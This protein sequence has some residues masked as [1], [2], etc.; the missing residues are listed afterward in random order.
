ML[1]NILG[2]DFESVS[3]ISSMLL[4]VN[5]YQYY[6]V[7]NEDQGKVPMFREDFTNRPNISV[8]PTKHFF[9]LRT[10]VQSIQLNGDIPE[11]RLVEAPELFLVT[12]HRDSRFLIAR[13]RPNNYRS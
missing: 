1:G 2:S 5:A 8:A 12:S 13:T 9:Q 10:F 7:C 4:F 6:P 11:F 3:S